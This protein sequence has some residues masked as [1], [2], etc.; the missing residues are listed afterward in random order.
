MASL[1]GRIWSSHRTVGDVE[2]TVEMQLKIRRSTPKRSRKK[3]ALIAAGA[4]G[5]AAGAVARK[6]H[7]QH[8]EEPGEGPAE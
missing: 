6:R 8:S 4:V 1:S 7:R 2:R 5:L 3:Q